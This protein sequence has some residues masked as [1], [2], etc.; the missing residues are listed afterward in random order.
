MALE[1]GNYIGNLV[2]A[3][4]SGSDRKLQGDDHLRL[5]KS[6]LQNCFAGLTGAVVVGGANGGVAN[7]YTL[8]PTPPLPSYV[9]NMSIVF[10]P[11][12]ANTGAATM[13]VSGLGAVSL[14]SVSGQ[15]LAAN[16]LV[17][18][19]K[20]RATF[21]GTNFRLFSVT[22][23]Y[24]DQLAFSSALPAQSLGF[25][26]ST[27]A[28]A[29]FTRTFSGYAVDESKGANVPSAA[30]I[31][32]QNTVV[33]G[34]LLHVTGTTTITAM[35]LPAGAERTL[36]F[37]GILTLTHSANLDLPGASNITTAVG[38]R[39]IVRGEGSGAVRVISYNKASGAAV[40]VTP[41]ALVLLATVNVTAVANIDFL[42]VFS[43]TFDEYLIIGDQI[44]PGTASHLNLRFANAGVV[45]SGSKY[46]FQEF[47][48]GTTFPSTSSSLID[49]SASSNWA[50]GVGGSFQIFVAN[51]NDVSASRPKVV[52][53]SGVMSPTAGSM[54]GLYSVADYV[55]A[56]AISGFRL[57][58]G[59]GNFQA[60]GQVRVYGISKT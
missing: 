21:D 47:S 54:L 17:P 45:D 25:L 36:V 15:A 59:A 8:L 6:V 57:L 44:T 26:A 2:S 32:L 51:V 56:N 37:D 38:D 24:V 14:L 29:A 49:L 28:V 39:A 58:W 13:N 18:G 48:A 3:N 60:N 19:Q 16:D 40:T 55:S 46:G 10:S 43:S 52:V 50:V 20:Y 31:D 41:P 4:P 42:N 30:T 9:D 12:I 35:T 1:T 23:N 5:V 33:T 34:N 27:G 7:A 53:V 11:V 22:K